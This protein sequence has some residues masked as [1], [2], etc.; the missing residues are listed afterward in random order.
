MIALKQ[1]VGRLIRDERDRGV[2]VIADP[3]ASGRGYGR[4]F[5]DSLPPMR[6]TRD[7]EDVRR[8][9]LGVERCK[10]PIRTGRAEPTICV[11]V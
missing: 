2:V 5:I 6:R 1:G 4:V 7:A 10:Q 3:R 8:N 9:G 11:G